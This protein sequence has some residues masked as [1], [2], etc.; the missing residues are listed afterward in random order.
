MLPNAGCG[1]TMNNGIRPVA[2]FDATSRV[3]AYE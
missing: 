2:W 1:P 3:A